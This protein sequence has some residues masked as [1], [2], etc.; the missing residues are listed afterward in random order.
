MRSFSLA[1]KPFQ[2]LADSFEMRLS[3]R[4]FELV[5]HVVLEEV[6]ARHA[7]AF[8]EPHQAA[9]V[10]H[11]PLVDVVE[12]LDQRIDARLVEPQ[13]LHLGDDLFL[14]LLVFALLRRRQR[15]VLQAEFDVLLLQAAQPLEGVGDGVE[16]LDH[17]RFELG[18]DRRHGERILHVVFVIVVRSRGLGRILRLFAVGG[19]ARRLE[20]RSGRRRGGRRHR[21]H[22]LQMRRAR[23]RRDAGNGGL[24]HRLAV[25][26]DDH[27]H[28]HLLGV[29][30]GVS[31]FQVDDVAQEDFSLA[32]FV[33]PD[34]DGLKRQWAFAQPCDHRLAAGFDSLGDGDFALA[35][36]QLDRAHLAQIHAH[37]IVGALG[38][39]FL[40]GDGQRL[41]LGLDHFAAGIVVVIVV[42]FVG[43][44]FGLAVFAFG[45][46][47]LDHVDA[48][49]AEHRHDVFD[50]FRRGR[51]RRQHGVE[52]VEG[53]KAPLLGG[54][55]HLL[56]AGIVEIE[57]RQ[58]G[59]GRALGFLVRGL[60]LDLR[61]RLA[62]HLLLL[63]LL[64]RAAS[65]AGQ[66]SPPI[67]RPWPKRAAPGRRRPRIRSPVSSEPV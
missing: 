46:L 58:R 45:V 39:L 5:A 12:L 19:L 20:R 56:D 27:R 41:R 14:E 8:A 47:G 24:R 52:R 23:N 18:F 37:G 3:Q 10:R 22:D 66:N 28:L 6:L 2:P 63:D 7:V 38:R 53:D 31:R 35:R 15:G 55:D 17:F 11:Q 60:V 59:F 40:L 42:V 32:Q 43:G 51:F 54:L 64:G 48:H 9:L 4:E 16:G 67:Y 34:D 13:R 33:A 29:G 61:L 44:L 49:L 26:A 50:L 25:G 62:R 57:Q 36:Q 65:E 21:L 30:A 1:T